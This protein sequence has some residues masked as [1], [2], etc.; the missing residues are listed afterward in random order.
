MFP[1][2]QNHVVMHFKE[3]IPIIKQCPTLYVTFERNKRQRNIL[4]MNYVVLHCFHLINGKSILFF[5]TIALRIVPFVSRFVCVIHRIKQDMEDVI[6]HFVIISLLVLG[7]W[8]QV[9]GLYFATILGG[10]IHILVS[11]ENPS[12]RFADAQPAQLWEAASWSKKH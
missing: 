1:Q 12:W 5:R 11:A 9:T 3:H 4:I 6:I 7:Q 10:A 2:G 8:A